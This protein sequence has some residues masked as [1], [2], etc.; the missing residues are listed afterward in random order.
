MA[1]MEIGTLL[2]PSSRRVAV[3]TISSSAPVP[4]EEPAALAL[5]GALASV[6]KAPPPDSNDPHAMVKN[7]SRWRSSPGSGF[8]WVAGITSPWIRYTVR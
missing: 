1:V 2:M 6:A 4:A 3:T 5:S 7:N 8:E